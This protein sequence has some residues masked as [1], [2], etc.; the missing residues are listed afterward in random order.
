MNK[1]NA[2]IE[3]QTA[4]LTSIFSIIRCICICASYGCH[5]YNSVSRIYI[6]AERIKCSYGEY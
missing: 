2:K 5:Y 1:P 3:T 6:N 4:A